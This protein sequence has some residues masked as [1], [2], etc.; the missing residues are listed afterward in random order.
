MDRFIIEGGHQLKGSVEVR[1][2]KNAVLPIIAASLLA[3]EGETVLKNIPAIQDVATMIKLLGTLGIRAHMDSNQQLR[4]D[5]RELSSIHADY[6]LVRKMRASVLVMGALLGRMGRCEVSLP[7]GCNI[8]ARPIDQHL[9]GLEQLGCT[10]EEVD[11][12]IV[13]T[14]GQLIGNNVYFDRPTH[15]GTENVLTAAVLAR[16]T[17]NIY[18]ASCEPEIKDVADFLNLMGAKIKGAGTPHI[19]VD[20]VES[21]SGIEYRPM[22]DRLEAG[23]YLFGAM[24]TGGDIKVEGVNP[25]HLGIVLYKMNEMGAEIETGEEHISLNMLGRPA[26]N[27]FITVPFPGFPTDLQPMAMANATISEG[28]SLVRETIFENRFTHAQELRRMGADIMDLGDRA[29]IRGIKHLKSAKVMASDIR[30]GA[31]LVLAGLAAKGKTEILR[32]YHIDRGYEM[33]EK[34]LSSLGAVIERAIS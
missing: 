20:G 13:G 27:N 10:F 22:G 21:L 11:G 19:I 23:T 32:V 7:G 25:E 5:A 26:A 34:K 14:V 24:M 6:E 12:Y 30:G 2:A 1:A 17:T 28:T 31:G 16:G 18:N 15:T 29:S 9:K 8:G 4:I 33:L 3:D